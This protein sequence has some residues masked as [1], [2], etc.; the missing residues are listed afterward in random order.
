V[1]DQQTVAKLRQVGVDLAQGF[2]ISAPVPLD[3]AMQEWQTPSSTALT[4]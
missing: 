1:E 4:R 2:G 3:N